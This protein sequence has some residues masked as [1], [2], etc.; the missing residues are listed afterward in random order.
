MHV[1]GYGSSTLLNTL[2]AGGADSLFQ[3]IIAN[4]HA[5]VQARISQAMKNITP[6]KDTAEYEKVTTSASSVTD[7]LNALQ[8]EKL[9][10]TESKDF[11]MDTLVSKISNFTNAYNNMLTNIGKVGKTVESEYSPEL[12]SILSH[13]E[14]DLSA[15]GITVGSDGKLVVD[16]DKMK[17]ADVSKLKELF[18]KDAEFAKALRAEVTDLNEVVSQAVSIQNKLSGLYDSSSSVVDYSSLLGGNTFDSLG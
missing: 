13:F 6:G 14:E 5:R 12:S 17:E 10:D 18:G 1:S 7:A 3:S 8:D 2:Q 4:N 9:W 11:S 16:T 15:V